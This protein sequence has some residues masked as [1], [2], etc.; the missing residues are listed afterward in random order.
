MTY[1]LPL[2]LE[3]IALP[4]KGLAV[5][6][7]KLRVIC[8]PMQSV[9]SAELSVAPLR[10]IRAIIAIR[11]PILAGKSATG[12]AFC[13]SNRA[14]HHA[15]IVGLLRH[16]GLAMGSDGLAE[17]RAL[18]RSG[19]ALARDAGASVVKGWIG[20][21]RASRHASPIETGPLRPRNPCM[22]GLPAHAPVIHDRRDRPLRLYARATRTGV[23]KLH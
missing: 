10:R 18:S 16:V 23:E 6:G 13:L 19:M 12:R 7:A 9:G 15:T 3:A 8:H 2:P 4:G 21:L 1:D 14:S 5:K 20:V 22:N 11:R 17:M